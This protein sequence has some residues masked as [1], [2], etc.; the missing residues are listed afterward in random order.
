MFNL[1]LK[2]NHYVGL[3]PINKVF[4][5]KLINL[6]KLYKQNILLFMFWKDGWMNFLKIIFKKK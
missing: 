6:E 4:F 3:K 5:S 1:E 2:T